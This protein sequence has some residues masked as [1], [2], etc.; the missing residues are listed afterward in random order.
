MR[1]LNRTWTLTLVA[2][3]LLALPLGFQP[4]YRGRLSPMKRLPG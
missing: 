2:G 3:L 4:C 1:R